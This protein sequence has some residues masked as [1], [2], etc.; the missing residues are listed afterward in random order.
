MTLTSR[1]L[2]LPLL[3]ATLTAGCGSFEMPD[4]GLQATSQKAGRISA[5]KPGNVR[6]IN[7]HETRYIEADRL[8][9]ESRKK[10]RTTGLWVSKEEAQALG[11]NTDS[12]AEGT[13]D[14][15]SGQVVKKEEGGIEKFFLPPKPLKRH[16]KVRSPGNSRFTTGM[17]HFDPDEE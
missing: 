17:T 8:K 6:F 3:C 13:A 9:T 12:V 5:T 2:A 11:V 16:M 15:K 14:A 1:T 4:L 7:T 10:L